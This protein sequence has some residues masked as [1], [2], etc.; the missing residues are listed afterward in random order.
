MT[1]SEPMFKILVF[2]GTSVTKVFKNKIYA[3]L[4]LEKEPTSSV[5]LSWMLPALRKHAF[6]GIYTRLIFHALSC[7]MCQV[8][9]LELA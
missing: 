1:F 5:R 8:S 4:V 6:E 3:L 7:P 9:F 2:A